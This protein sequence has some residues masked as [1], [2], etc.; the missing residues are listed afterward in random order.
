M[1]SLICSLILI[2]VLSGP[3]IADGAGPARII[4]G[5]TLALGPIHIR[6]ASIDAPEMRQTCTDGGGV[7]YA[8]GWSAKTALADLINDARVTCRSVGLD[9]YGRQVAVCR[10]H[11]IPDLGA[12]MVRRGWA[13]DFRKYDRACTYCALEAEAKAAGKGMWDGKFAMPWQWRADHAK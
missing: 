5:D 6:L 3:A 9:I 13:V 1:K 10:T 8:C 11:A 4:D 2:L 7:D 12:E